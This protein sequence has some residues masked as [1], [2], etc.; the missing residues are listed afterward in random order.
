MVN[1]RLQGAQLD[2]VLISGSI[3]K[4]LFNFHRIP[5]EHLFVFW[6]NYG[7]SIDY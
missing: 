5:A 4:G 3:S 2:V 7:Q 1:T 6:S